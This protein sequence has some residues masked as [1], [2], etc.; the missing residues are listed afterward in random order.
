VV[1]KPTEVIVQEKKLQFSYGSIFIPVS[2]QTISSEEL[3]YTLNNLALK[4]GVKVTGLESGYR[5][6]GLHLGSSNLVPLKTPKTLML[7]GNGINSRQAGEIWHLMDYRMDMFLT[8]VDQDRF[9]RIKL[10]DYNTLILPEGDYSFTK[11]QMEEIQIW[12][13]NGG[14]IITIG[15]SVLTFKDHIN[16]TAREAEKTDTT[17]RKDYILSDELRRQNR[18]NGVILQADVDITHPIGYGLNKTKIPVFRNS[19]FVMEKTNNPYSTPVFIIN[20]LLSGYLNDKSLNYVSNS[21][22]INSYSIGEGHIIAFTDNP[23]FRAIWFGTN[24]L[25]LNS[26]FFGQ[27]IR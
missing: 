11:N 27:I 12:L 23:N 2:K 1:T 18:I 20:E 6:T 22:Y 24:K 8:R 5:N 7:I 21:A 19:N 17:I 25:F 14:N 9:N 16:I 10:F 15:E 26:I 3:Y 4:T 13:K